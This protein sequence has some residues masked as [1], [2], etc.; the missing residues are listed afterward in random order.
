MP[1]HADIQRRASPEL[2]SSRQLYEAIQEIAESIVSNLRASAHCAGDLLDTE[3]D[4]RIDIVDVRQQVEIEME[5]VLSIR[6]AGKG[7]LARQTQD[8]LED[9]DSS[10]ATREDQQVM[11]T[12]FRTN[13]ID[14]ADRIRQNVVVSS[15]S[16]GAPAAYSGST[17]R[18]SGAIPPR[19]FYPRTPTPTSRPTSR[20]PMLL[21]ALF[22]Q[23][24]AQLQERISNF[25]LD[26]LLAPD[27][28]ALHR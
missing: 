1:A 2:R 21:N 24:S 28:L 6:A 7:E 13:V 18:N 14:V 20:R 4:L 25:I 12:Q 27:Q 3:S 8:V 9:M 17:P 11:Q 10:D 16:D 23:E 5:R 26:D 22:T 15:S 19:S